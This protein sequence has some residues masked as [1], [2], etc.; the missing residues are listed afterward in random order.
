MRAAST[1]DEPLR[2]G[3]FAVMGRTADRQPF[4]T[5]AGKSSGD[6]PVADQPPQ[7]NQPPDAARAEHGRGGGRAA[8]TIELSMRA[9]DNLFRCR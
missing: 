5:D 8:L 6:E 3:P 2:L 1:A 9:A 7:G 4:P